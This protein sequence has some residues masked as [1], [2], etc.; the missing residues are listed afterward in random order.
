MGLEPGAR[1]LSEQPECGSWDEGT[2]MAA[3]RVWII[4]SL[5]TMC[6]SAAAGAQIFLP[7][8]QRD[9]SGATA[10][11]SERRIPVGT[12]SICG[13]VA[14]E[15]GRP[16]AGVRVTVNGQTRLT[17]SPANLEQMWVT[18]S[19]V[20][21][22]SGE[23]SFPRLPAGAFTLAATHPQG[24]LLPTN[25]GQRRAGGE[26]QVIQL[27]D[28]QKL[29]LNFSMQSGSVISGL[30]VGPNGE[31]QAGVQVRAMRF[32][33]SSGFK[34]LQGAKY[35]QTDDRGMYRMFG[36]APG[37]YLVS[38]TPN[39]AAFYN[40]NPMG[41]DAEVVERAIA[42]G[43]V[44]PAEVTGA[45]PTVAV[46]LPT[47]WQMDRR[48]MPSYL[49]T[50]APDAMSPA[51]AT[52]IS[53]TGS[54]ERTGIN[55]QVRLVTATIINGVISTPLDPGVTVQVWLQSDDTAAQAF[56]SNQSSLDEKGVFTFAGVSPGS[57]TLFAHTTV[58]EPTISW[59]DGESRQSPKNP[60]LT[61]AQKMWGLTRIT[62]TGEPRF[63][64][65]LSL[66]PSR[67]ISGT[68]LFDMKQ[69]P[70]LSQLQLKVIANPAP[71]AQPVYIE[72]RGTVGPDGRF[73]ISG[74]PA[75]RWVLGLTGCDGEL[76]SAMV[77]GQDTLDIPLEFT[78]D[79]DV[80]DAVLT[81]VDEMSDLSGLLTDS[82]GKPAPG[83]TIIVA[84]TDSRYWTPG[85]RR[86]MSDKARVNGEYEFEGLP[87]GSYGISVVTD[88]EQGALSDPEFLRA[89]SR[90]A[91]PVLIGEKSKVTQNLR[92]K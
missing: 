60:P 5:W 41:V 9:S 72:L 27:A 8:G 50:Y 56:Q 75:G 63:P 74:V 45:L 29:T 76:K 35:A 28:G 68:V 89:L 87:A 65:N 67:S 92:V 43:P 32:D 46:P 82:A 40:S 52:A 73:T 1:A 38:A 25:Y 17:P 59:V 71:S 6:M 13:K 81:V 51:D 48:A 19:V 2:A 86:V 36:L 34:R 64:V 66:Q 21:D 90:T 47:P 77:S 78:G 55:I 18:R 3:G 37:D 83:Y 58:A 62:V 61:D 24:L 69:R 15:A 80:S 91:I 53:V 49:P 10:Q 23:F 54:D 14:T 11:P 26:G 22:V 12:S 20:T 44:R 30:V 88:L 33:R 79:R 42:S 7:T 4:A 31:P 84:P 85:S 39:A 16:V 57:Y 70:D